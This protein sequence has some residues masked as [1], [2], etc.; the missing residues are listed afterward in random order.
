MNH[1]TYLNTSRY[2]SVLLQ[3]RLL[4]PRP[5]WCHKWFTLHI[6]MSHGAHVNTSC[7]THVRMQTLIPL[8]NPVWVGVNI[9]MDESWHTYECVML[10]NCDLANVKIVHCTYMDFPCHKWKHSD[11]CHCGHNATQASFANRALY[12][13]TLYYRA[14]CCRCKNRRLSRVVLSGVAIGILVAHYT[15]WKC[16]RAHYVYVLLHCKHTHMRTYT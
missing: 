1:D 5:R 13:I 2:K 11:W 9:R 7:H 12:H 4:D 6:W 15:L 10:Q 14:L 3:R 8:A 16:L